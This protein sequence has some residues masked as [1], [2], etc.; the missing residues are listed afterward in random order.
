M[1]LNK[2]DVKIERVSDKCENGTLNIDKVQKLLTSE[3]K[4]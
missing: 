2:R 1:E 3:N 4:K